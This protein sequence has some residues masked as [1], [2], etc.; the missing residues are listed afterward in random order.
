MATEG[1]AAFLSAASHPNGSSV[2]IARGPGFRS[3]PA[4]GRADGA[5]SQ[6]PPLTNQRKISGRLWAQAR[7]SLSWG[8]AHQS[9]GFNGPEG[10]IE[11][12]GVGEGGE[13]EKAVLCM[14]G[15]VQMRRRGVI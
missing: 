9:F 15:V 10:G 1:S 7:R 8:Q 14:Q 12:K 13:A 5:K 2:S 4:S 6:G 11:E 3:E